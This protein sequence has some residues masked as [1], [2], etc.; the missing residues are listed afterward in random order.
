L[1][2][3][4]KYY[5]LTGRSYKTNDLETKTLAEK[6]AGGI[7]RYIKKELSPGD[8]LPPNYDLA[9]MFNVSVKTIHDAVKMLT[10]EGI[11]YSRRGKYGTVVLDDNN[12]ISHV[13]YNYENIEQKLR[14]KI[15]DNYNI[16]DK[17]PSIK[18]LAKEYKTSE[19]TVKKALDN[20]K[21]DG[22]IAFVR[23]RWG[24]TFVTDI[25]QDSK[26]AYT[27]IALNQNY[28]PN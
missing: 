23:G 1:E 28:I 27:W 22:C 13:M 5:V 8:K 3:K 18:E 25:P 15:I 20:L 14:K 17:L 19:K 11:L 9:A 7:Q 4:K 6:I 16:N 10:K 21:E 2:K 12:G 24:G 26:D